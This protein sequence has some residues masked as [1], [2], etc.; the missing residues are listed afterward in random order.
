MDFAKN[1]I[2]EFIT[3]IRKEIFFLLLLVDPNTNGQYPNV[4]VNKVFEDTLNIIMGYNELMGEPV[5]IVRTMSLLKRAQMNYN[6]EDFDFKFYR[7]LIL[8]AGNEILKA[9]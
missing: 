5:A 2:E 7:K 6:S 9:V 4:D 1:Q 8:D 3:I